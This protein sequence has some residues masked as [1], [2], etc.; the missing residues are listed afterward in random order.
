MIARVSKETEETAQDDLRQDLTL[1]VSP[2]IDVLQL[3]G[4]MLVLLACSLSSLLLS[5]SSSGLSLDHTWPATS[6]RFLGDV[7]LIVRNS[8]RLL[9]DGMGCG[10]VNHYVDVSFRCFLVVGRS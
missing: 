5:R 1:P 6:S 2:K 3:T 10:F 8:G 4:A 9:D 7:Q